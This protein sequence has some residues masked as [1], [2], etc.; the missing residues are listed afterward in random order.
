[1]YCLESAEYM[2]MCIPLS[3]PPPL[4]N[5]SA[6]PEEHEQN[7]MRLCNNQVVNIIG[8][9]RGLG[10][11]YDSLKRPVT[12]SGKLSHRTLAIR[13]PAGTVHCIEEKPKRKY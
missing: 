7:S 10:T 1:M 3:P 13:Q 9:A 2:N 11:T 4:I 5:Y 12:E 8:A 6:A